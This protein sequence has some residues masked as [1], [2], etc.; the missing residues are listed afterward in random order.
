MTRALARLALAT[1][2]VVTMVA[3][4]A[5]DEAP[6]KIGTALDFS[7]LYTRLVPVYSQGQRDCVALINSRGG[8][9]GH[10]MELII[11]DHGS[12][13]QRGI[14]AYQRFKREGAVLVDLLSTPV[15]RAVVPMALADGMNVMTL[16]HG[17]GD[18]ADGRVFPTIFPMVATYW[19][20]AADIVKYIEDEERE[21]IKGKRIALVAEDNGVGH[22]PEPVFQELSKRLGFRFA[23]FYY[24]PPGTDQAATW[25]Q[26]Y[27][28]KPDWTIIWGAGDA[29]SQSIREALAQGV[30]L[31]H[32]VSN[33][34][35][36]ETDLALAGAAKAA[37]LLRFEGVA[38]GRA[39]PIIAAIEREVIAAGKGAG[40]PE[41]VGQTYYNAG[42][43][44]MALIAEG[45]RLALEN[46]GEPLT[47]AKLKQ[48]LEE[49][50]DFTAEDLLP[51]TSITARD[52]QGGGR[53]RIVQWDGTKWE[54]RRHWFAAYQDI[55][56]NLI[57]KSS[58][59]YQANGK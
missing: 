6:I 41:N 2:L 59:Q 49:L 45:A 4:A 19:S 26:A 58:Q 28:F 7:V 47:A 57:L 37:G 3:A 9:K 42:V 55:V 44:S 16:L 36:Q 46:E 29:Q 21:L 52:H 25:K 22:E 30:K 1:G 39:L 33:V 20:Q 31:D 35:M 34:N 40:P 15:S 23:A 5:A 10:P 53:G 24:A 32:V 17:R 13:P 54:E 12:D 18:A 8:I 56:W 51:P 38:T 50:R 11:V 43:A 27:R 14:D 48:G